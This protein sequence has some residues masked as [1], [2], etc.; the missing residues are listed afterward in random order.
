[1]S[2]RPLRAAAAAVALA[3]AVSCRTETRGV[4]LVTLDT[5]RAD[6]LGCYGYADAETPHLDALAES[7]VRFADAMAPVPVTLPSHASMFT[8]LLPP[9]HGVRYNGMFRLGQSSETI[10]ERLSAAGWTTAGVSAGFS[11]AA[12]TG[13]AQGFATYDDVAADLAPG[14]DPWKS[15]KNAAQVTDLGIAFLRRLGRERFFLW[16]HYW[17]PHEP[18][19]PPFPFSARHHD[20]PYDGEIAYVDHELGR[21]FDALR[22]MKLWDG[23]LVIVAGDHGEG[24]YE[25]NEKMHANLVYQ[26]TLHVPLI[27]KPPGR[28]RPRVVEETVSLVDVAP[29]ILDFAGVAGPEMEG[30]SLKPA[31]YGDEPPRRSLYFESLAGSLVHGWSPL[32]GV[33]RG[34]FKYTRSTEPELFDLVADPREIDN[35]AGAEG[36]E[37]FEL[38]EALEQMESSWRQRGSA[39]EPT[40]VPLDPAEAEALAS[41]GYLGGFVTD[42]R[43]TGPH[44][45]DRIY[46][47]GDTLVARDHMLEGN[48]A[49]VLQH[50]EPVLARD[51]DNRYALQGAA[52]ACAKLGRHDQAL[53]YT[54]RMLAIYPEF[55]PGRILQG[56]IRASRGD[57]ERAAEEFRK[58]LEYRPEES[59][60]TYRLAVALFAMGRY[61][62]SK[63]I[64][65]RMIAKG[66]ELPSFL[67]L[68]AACDAGLGDP[69]GS[70]QS[71]RDAIA[72]GYN[73]REVLLTEPLLE[74]LRTIP[75]F[76][77]AVEAIPRS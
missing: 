22:D 39:V 52:A 25:H 9:V 44:P 62:E 40:S 45:K 48:Y 68:R 15:D 76:D 65:D 28:A 70:L 21:L 41:L 2:V 23:T 20:R 31:A 67:V 29:T 36:A 61:P 59:G 10:A 5:T 12:N 34:R 32:E 66:V 46:L 58:G 77:E 47:E 6:R 60:L 8:G 26:S 64:A 1:V 63:E 75:G 56:E 38:R 16:L 13:I 72:R 30:I 42:E 55:T 57:L 54:G 17:D 19:E 27:V 53:E 43:R 50:L 14:D 7:G 33:R 35:V 73:D 69:G 24:L 49:A 11:L 18:Y 51:P 71:L 37:A 3:A 4:L 74:P